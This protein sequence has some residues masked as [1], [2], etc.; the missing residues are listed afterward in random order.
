MNS[1]FA[2]TERLN[3]RVV[4]IHRTRESAEIQLGVYTKEFPDQEFG[5]IEWILRDDVTLQT[6]LDEA[7]VASIPFLTPF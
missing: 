3:G 7:L 4:G 6:V 1:V 2:V 5:V